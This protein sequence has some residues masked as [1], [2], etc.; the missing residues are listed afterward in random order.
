MIDRPVGRGD[1]PGVSPPDVEGAGGGEAVEEA[2]PVEVPHPGPASLGFDD[3]EARRAHDSDLLGIQVRRELVERLLLRRRIGKEVDL[4]RPR[5]VDA[6]II[7]RRTLHLGEFAWQNVRG[8][9]LSF[10]VEPS[11]EAPTPY[12]CELRRGA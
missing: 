9:E 1:Y 5:S 6:R 4:A 12:I 10:L 7:H 8:E 3:V 2:T 11:P